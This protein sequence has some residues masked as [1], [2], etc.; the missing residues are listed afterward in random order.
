MLTIVA[1]AALSLCITD[2]ADKELATL[3]DKLAQAEN[4]S[5]TSQT[6]TEGGGFGRGGFGGGRGGAGGAPPAP[7]VTTGTYKKG[8]PL[9]VKQ[10]EVEA[11]KDGEQLVYK[12]EEGKWEVLDSNSFGRGGFGGDGGG[13]GQRGGDDGGGGQRGRRGGGEG[14]GEGGRRG[15]DAGGGQDRGGFAGMRALFGLRGVEAPHTQFA[16][17]AEKIEDVAVKA[18]AEGQ[19]GPTVYSGKLKKE[20]A[21]ELGGGFGRG[22]GGFGGGR[23]GARGGEGGVEGPQLET[24]GTFVIT[25]DKGAITKVQFEVTTSGSFGE[26]EFE[27]KTKRELTFAKIG[28]TTLE[29]PADALAKFEI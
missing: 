21:Q 23:G 3:T 29:V 5:F 28:E 4:Y 6:T 24:A 7:P 9:H 18:P 19:E 13:R 16:G 17:F 15:G 14:G 10:G 22:R 12:N 25:V 20:A 8:M 11:Y 2:G 27:M 1:S 26:R